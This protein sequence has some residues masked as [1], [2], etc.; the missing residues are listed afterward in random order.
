M[1]G[2]M[3]T[4]PCLCRPCM[5]S[6]GSKHKF[7][8][9]HTHAHPESAERIEEVSSSSSLLLAATVISCISNWDGVIS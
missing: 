9:T 5:D 4:R 8:H 2:G 1:S 6:T 3:H 7:T